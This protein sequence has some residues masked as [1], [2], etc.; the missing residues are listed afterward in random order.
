MESLK[1]QM[2]D[3]ISREPTGTL[4]LAMVA[5]LLF[6][7]AV[8][9]SGNR[10][11][12]WEWMRTILEALA[13]ALIFMGLAW[14]GYFLLVNNYAAFEKV[15]HSFTQYGSDSYIAQQQWKR[16]YGVNFLQQDDLEVTQYETMETLESVPVGEPP[17]LLYKTTKTEKMVSQ[18]DITRFR[19]YVVIQ[20]VDWNQRDETFNAY[21]MSASY[22]YDVINPLAISTRAEFRFPLFGGSKLYQDVIVKVDQREI[23]WSVRDGAIVWERSMQPNEKTS[24]SIQYT[25]WSMDGFQFRIA[26]SREVRDFKMTIAIDTALC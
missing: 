23:D 10:K 15:H 6:G 20:G 17:I 22:D 4:W 25:T 13:G 3:W 5:V 12:P 8:S 24:I 11:D 14:M 18:N 19:G 16:I 26:K 9:R 2:T 7:A 21:T 1:L